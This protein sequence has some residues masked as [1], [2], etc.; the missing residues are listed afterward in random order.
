MLPGKIEM[1][2]SEQAQLHALMGEADF[3]RQAGPQIN[4]AIERLES[5]NNELAACYTRWQ[6]LESQANDSHN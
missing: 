5:I 1:L 4:A 2:E 6:D 3:Y